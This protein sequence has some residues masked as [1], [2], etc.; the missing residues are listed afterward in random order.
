[1][2]STR[3]RHA[4]VVGLFALCSATGVASASAAPSGKLYV[5]MGDSVTRC[6][7]LSGRQYPERF[8][9]VLEQRGR[10][11]TLENIGVGGETSSSIRGAQLSR[12]RTLIADP[13]TDTTVLTLDIGGNDLLHSSGCSASAPDFSLAM[14]QPT[15]R[16]FTANYT[17]L[18]DSL[19]TALAADPGPE[20]LIVVGY[21]NPSSGR[22]GADAAAANTA[23]VLLGADGRVDCAGQGAA[24][25]L[26]DI[27]ACVGA[28]RGAPFADLYPAFLGK[29]DEWF[30][31][32][33]HPNDAGHGAI[34]D[35]LAAA[36]GPGGDSA[37]PTLAVPGTI[38]VDA[39]SRRGALV[40]YEASAV[41]DRDPHPEIRCVPRSGARFAIGV[42]TVFCSAADTDGNVTRASFKVSVH[43]AGR[44][45]RDLV[46]RLDASGL[47]AR[48][49]RALRS[50]LRLAEAS[51]AR[52]AT[53]DAR[54]RL[55]RFAAAVRREAGAGLSVTAASDL[56]SRARRIRAVLR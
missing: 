19:V 53:R 33:V 32:A 20:R 54:L 52:G 3:I 8:F 10:A 16:A 6:C 55:V 12:A 30:A 29:G 48:R 25:G 45:L 17:A 35:M 47:P 22:A 2:I 11:D 13:R 51:V 46:V 9:R 1:V 44:Q 7:S 26:N 21:Y 18:L 39:T 56:I 41:D 37:A 50:K 5:A 40:R 24:L 49:R 31:D 36:L 14:C 4:L 27:V 43:G 38:R 15:L 34:V 42:T 23:S 28:Q